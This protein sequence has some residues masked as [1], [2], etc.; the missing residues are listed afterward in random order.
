MNKQ[1][2]QHGK[3]I[4]YDRPVTAIEGIEPRNNL[5]TIINSRVCPSCKNDTTILDGLTG[6]IICTS[7]GT[8]VLDRQEMTVNDVKAKDRSGMP[9]SLAFPDK[10]LSTVINYSNTDANGVYLNETQVTTSNKIR[11]MDKILGNNKNHIRNFRNAFAIMAT[12]SDKLGLTDPVIERAAYYYRKAFDS[13]LIKGRAIKEM[14]V[15]GIYAACKEMSVPRTL[16]EAA[17]AANADPVFSGR[18]YRI[19]SRKLRISHSI[20]DSTSYISK[21]ATNA[22]ISQQTYR[23]AVDLLSIVKENPIC[24]GKDPK[25]V[26][27]AVLYASCLKK[28]ESNISQSKMAMAGDISIVTLRKRLADI[29]KICPERNYMKVRNR[30]K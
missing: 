11:Y 6:E 4:L 2:L 7:C 15:A 29:I 19:M 27:T 17:Y 21:I 24:H 23:E 30:I 16:Q 5:E 22:Q 12:V 8:V 20:V 10:G 9:S 3:Y 18:C 14:V 13:R 25:A 28:G 1:N 26:A